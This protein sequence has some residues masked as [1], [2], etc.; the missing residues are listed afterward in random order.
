MKNPPNMQVHK[1]QAAVL[2]RK[3]GPLKIESL[4]LE[5]WRLRRAPG[6]FRRFPDRMRSRAVSMG[7]GSICRMRAPMY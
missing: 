7:C 5:I 6:Y 1:I 3:G 2:R 4:D